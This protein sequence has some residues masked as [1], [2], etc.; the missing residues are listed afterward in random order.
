AVGSGD[1][2]RF[3]I[4]SRRPR[5]HVLFSPSRGYGSAPSPPRGERAGVRGSLGAATSRALIREH[6]RL[7]QHRSRCPLTLPSP[8][9]GEGKARLALHRSRSPL[10][11][12]SPHGGE[13]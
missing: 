2:V 12:P 3:L 8:H 5:I 10:T 4:C 7:D 1:Q 11:L 6:I 13:G 9:G